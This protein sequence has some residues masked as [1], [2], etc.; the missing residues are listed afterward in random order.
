MLASVI[1]DCVTILEEPVLDGGLSSAVA[2]RVVFSES[3]EFMFAV[4]E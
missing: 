3:R 4:D 1:E 2:G